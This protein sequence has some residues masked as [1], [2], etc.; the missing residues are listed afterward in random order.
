MKRV[1]ATG[2]GRTRSREFTPVLLL[3]AGAV[4]AAGGVLAP[5]WPLAIGG[6]LVVTVGVVRMALKR[7][8]APPGERQRTAGEHQGTAGEDRRSTAG[9]DSTGRPDG[10]GQMVPFGEPA[11]EPERRASLWRR[12]T[13]RSRREPTTASTGDR[14]GKLPPDDENTCADDTAVADPISE[15]S[16]AVVTV[17]PVTELDRTTVPLPRRVVTGAADSSTYFGGRVVGQPFEVRGASLPGLTHL[18]A[19]EPG[20]D[21]VAA[22]WSSYRSSLLIAVADGVGSQPDSG[23]VASFALRR[24]L[25]L[26]QN[27]RCRQVTLGRLVENV[28]QDTIDDLRRAGYDGSTTLVVAELRPVPGGAEADIVAVGDSEAWLL[29]N[30]SWEALY[31]DRGSGTRALPYSPA[32][33]EVRLLITP[34]TVLMLATDGVAEALGSGS[35]ALARELAARLARPPRPVEFANLL[36]FRHEMFND[37][38]SAVAVWLPAQP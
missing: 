35:S 38:R 17:G 36:E 20:Q 21:R 11:A 26:G 8:D 34:G 32:R 16:L 37:D 19:G 13:R 1:S 33:H 14:P 27:P 10:D 25:D 15:T 29:G 22:G 23:P 5:A 24:L 28:R 18:L 7:K 3:A 2:D 4:I 6:I 30:N 12:L 9:W 31:H